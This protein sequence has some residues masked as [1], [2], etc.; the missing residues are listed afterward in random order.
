MTKS[1]QL[2]LFI[3][4]IILLLGNPKHSYRVRGE[5]ADDAVAI[6]ANLFLVRHDLSGIVKTILV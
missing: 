2:G 4:S 5:L 1:G 3:H 6:E